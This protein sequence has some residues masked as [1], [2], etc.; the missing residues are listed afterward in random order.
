MS[1][2][3]LG[4]PSLSGK[5][6]NVLVEAAFKDADFPMQLEVSNLIGHSLC[7]PEINDLFLSPC[8]GDRAILVVEIDAYATLQRLASS[9]EQIAELNQHEAMVSIQVFDPTLAD[10]PIDLEDK[11]A[12]SEDDSED[13]AADPVEAA[14]PV[15]DGAVVTG[16]KAGK[17]KAV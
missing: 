17:E 3:I 12:D 14:D 11:A 6:A 5:D 16:K 7:F 8:Y 1:K 9:I 10:G 15:I 2:V 4:A 13:P